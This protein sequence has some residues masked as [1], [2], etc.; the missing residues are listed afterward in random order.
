MASLVSEHR[1][2][3]RFYE[4]VHV[5]GDQV[6]R[7][8]C[9]ALHAGG[10]A[11]AIARPLALAA[12]EVQ[13]AGAGHDV[14]ALRA[15]GRL[16]LLDATE[17]LPK[18][19]VNDAID[20][21]AFH[22]HIATPLRAICAA[23]AGHRVHAYG[24]LVDI[25]WVAGNRS[26]VLALERLW[27][28]Q[29][30]ELPFSLSCGYQLRGFRSDTA[31]LELICEHHDSVA[32]LDRPV[33]PTLTASRV[34]A[35]AEQRARDLE[36]EVARRTHL[37][38]RMLA[39]LELS[40]LLAAAS[41]RETIA[42][43]TVEQGTRAVGAI[44]AGLWL[45][46][47]GATHLELLGASSNRNNGAAHGFQR[48]S[49]ISDTPL[50]HAVRTGEPVFLRNLDDYAVQ[51][52]ASRVR[53]DA[54]LTASQRA[55]AVVPVVLDCRP[56]GGI[57]FTF[58][59]EREFSKPDR[60]FKSILARQC[61]LALA[62]VQ[63][64][65]QERA[66]REAAERAAV[67]ER[68]ARTEIELLYDLT[69]Q[70]NQLDDLAAVHDL[71]LTTVRRGTHSDRAA[72]L[73]FDDDGVMRFKA[74]HGLSETYQRAV[75]GHTPWR[76]DVVGPV[77]IAVDD[78]EQ[79]PAW[80]AYRPVFRAEGIRALAFVPVVHQRQL[81]GKFMLYRNEPRPFTVRE[82]QLAV[83][84]AIH[85][86]QA[87]ERKHAE[88]RLAHAYR[89]EREAHLLA[90]E[91][92]RAR[93]EILSVVSHDLRTPLGTILMG[94]TTLLSV[95][96]GER[97][98]RVRTVAERIHRQAE[99]MARLIEDLVDFAGIQAGQL[100]ITVKPHKPDEIL[101]A[102]S[103]MFS[104][105]AQERGLQFE[106][107]LTPG[108]PHVE[109]DSERAV[110]VMSNLV[111]NALKVTP[112]GGAIAIGAEPAR[113]QVVFYVRDTGPGID[114]DE[115]PRLFERYWRGKDPQ[116]KGAGLGLSIARGIVD[117]HG[118]RIWAES[119]PG[120]GTTF[121]FSLA[122]RRNN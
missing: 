49:I 28:E 30:R 12:I 71:A 15:R 58:D 38:R 23:A 6:G 116:Y 92:T 114:A 51:F 86:G 112:K 110:Q 32:P 14:P 113:D 75:E 109:C 117:A 64:Q 82:L 78:T 42:R 35:Q 83:T 100:A 80:A 76:R 7:Y 77:P 73:L 66:Q 94:A 121:Y 24:E 1:H 43:L 46:G 16:E 50:A 62:R 95:E 25:L 72:I 63:L 34:L 102:T 26:A 20:G 33:D 55:F 5:L 39:L 59:H 118:G 44:D 81:I 99:R 17:L 36:S 70:V 10:A 9:E 105:L 13:L 29:L 47:P 85:V 57:V 119:Q 56:L 41:D 19:L 87:V 74:A 91:A 69:S 4:D 84:V 111:A 120:A 2:Q 97:G 89:E 27:S 108:L 21:A 107:R 98:H 37:E 96:A 3:V 65:E 40:G 52:P 79:D 60:A 88:A 90:E 68:E 106:A 67:A 18:L 93:E 101:S 8:L 22:E 31:G 115:M 45:V 122:G 61:A 54:I 11:L 104:S 48:V 103:D 53:L